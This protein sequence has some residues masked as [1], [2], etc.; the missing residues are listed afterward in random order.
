MLFIDGNR[1]D[2]RIE[3]K[4]AMTERYT[5]DKLTIPAEKVL[6]YLHQHLNLK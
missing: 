5:K 4:E 2:P 6:D 3:T 1:I